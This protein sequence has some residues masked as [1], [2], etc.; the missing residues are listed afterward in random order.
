MILSILKLV[1]ETAEISL[2]FAVIFEFSER[3][4]AFRTPAK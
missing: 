4:E 1:C 3:V 2:P